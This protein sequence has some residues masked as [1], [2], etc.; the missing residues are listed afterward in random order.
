MKKIT[1]SAE[2]IKTV[3]HILQFWRDQSQETSTVIAY[4]NALAVFDCA[5]E[6]NLERLHQWDSTNY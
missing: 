2:T 6:N 3:R 1:L 4:K 5:I